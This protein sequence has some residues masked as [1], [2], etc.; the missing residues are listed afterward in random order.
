MTVVCEVS[1]RCGQASVITHLSVN[2]KCKSQSAYI[3]GGCVGMS[4]SHQPSRATK[5]QLSLFQ[6]IQTTV[7]MLFVRLLAFFSAMVFGASRCPSAVFSRC[8]DMCDQGLR[9]PT[10]AHVLFGGQYFEAA[11][12]RSHIKVHNSFVQKE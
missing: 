9:D 6:H 4:T 10:V 11:C 2:T 8:N 1:R 7:T 12:V 5:E 3:K